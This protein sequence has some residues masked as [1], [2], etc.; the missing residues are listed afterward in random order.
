[1]DA[2]PP[3]CLSCCVGSPEHDATIWGQV[4]LA[5][6]ASSESCAPDLCESRSIGCG[7]SVVA[8]AHG[9]I[10]GGPLCLPP[11]VWQIGHGPANR[12]DVG[13]FMSGLERPDSMDTPFAS[14]RR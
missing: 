2:I 6:A 11:A 8:S 14:E 4:M 7:R 3:T 5:T 12:N 10:L 9:A 1:M 13:S